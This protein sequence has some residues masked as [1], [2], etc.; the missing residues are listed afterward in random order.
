MTKYPFSVSTALIFL[1]L[2]ALV[3]MGFTVLVAL[4]AHPGLPEPRIAQWIMAA[5]AFGSACVLMV[6]TL[7]LRK[8]VRVAYYLTLGSLAL[9]AVLTITDEVGW[10]DWLYLAIVVVPLLLLIKDRSW[11]LRHDSGTESRSN[12]PPEVVSHHF[13]E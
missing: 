2:N 4:N 8:R 9:L 13:I 12:V 1:L 10:A 5:L 7:L 6:L 11:Y 3:W